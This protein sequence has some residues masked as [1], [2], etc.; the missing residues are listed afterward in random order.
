MKIA[1]SAGHNV[2]N[3]G[4]FDVGSV[5][6]NRKINEASITKKTVSLLK[7][8]LEKMGHKVYD[9]TPY[10]QR[11]TSSK[12]A[13]LERSKR[14]KS[15]NPDIYLDIH[16]NAGGGTGPE[17][18]VYSA[19]SKAYSYARSITNSIAKNTELT[20][21]RGVRVKPGYWSVSLHPQP[22]II[23]E[24]GFIDSPSGKDMEVLTPE[25]YARSIASCFGEIK[26]NT[27]QKENRELYRV[28]KNWKD[29]KSQIGVYTNLENAK[30]LA[31][32]NL[33][34]FVFDESGF[35]IYP[36]KHWADVHFD[37]LNKNGIEVEQK[38]FNDPITRGEAMAL[39]HRLHEKLIGEVKLKPEKKSD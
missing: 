21:K 39:L 15:I 13:H 33:G 38:R 36:K 29:A 37:Y 27:L 9:I 18:L 14:V 20:N 3:N 6:P 11:F 16:I 23:I 22:S 31:D 8:M 5:S 25:I 4:V 35:I 26:E 24:G 32:A 17:T 19:H 7:P 34:Y 12:N 30:K 10:N 2:Y 28:R 1:L